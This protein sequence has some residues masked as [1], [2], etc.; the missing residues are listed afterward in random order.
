MLPEITGLSKSWL[1]PRLSEKSVNQNAPAPLIG[2]PD[3]RFVYKARFRS[4]RL[5]IVLPHRTSEMA[6]V[7]GKL[8]DVMSAR[9]EVPVTALASF[10]LEG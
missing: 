4:G 6:A 8:H 5:C 7:R 10:W 2:S 3:A 1:S 9:L